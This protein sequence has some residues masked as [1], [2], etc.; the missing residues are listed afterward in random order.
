MILNPLFP[1]VKLSSRFDII[2]VETNILTDF[3]KIT[4]VDDIN[5]NDVRGL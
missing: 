4:R 2:I 1:L 3:I 5:I